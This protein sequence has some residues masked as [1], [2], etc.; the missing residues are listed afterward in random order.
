MS[1]QQHTVVPFLR[2]MVVTLGPVEEWQS[3]ASG[4]VLEF[5]SD[6][7][8]DSFRIS[9]NIQKTV[10]GVPNP[11]T[12]NI[13]NLSDKTRN[14]LQRSLTKITVEA[15]WENT[16]MHKVFQG[17]LVS[18]QS[19]RQGA[20]IVTKI[21]AI[22]GYGALVRSTVSKTYGEG[23]PIQDVL[24]DLGGTLEGVTVNS[25]HFKEVQGTLGKGGWSFAG[26]TQD[27]MTELASE[28]GFSW[29]IDDN[30]LNAIGDKAKFDGMVVLYGKDGGLINVSPI[31]QGPMQVQTG[32]KISAIY[33]PGVQPGSTVR[34]RSTVSQGLDGDYRIHTAAISLD[35]FSDAW[36]MQLE[37]FRYM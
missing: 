12:I 17:S 5:V 24:K 28:Y 15:G 30:S 1:Q 32:V 26:R 34:V 20:D 11:S 27:A 35:T 33:V 2:K 21:A 29:N 37:S 6:G 31:L 14:A 25:D 3:G 23:M 7:T 10:M 8:Q 18:C 4:D 19:A 16:E 22:P 13:Y 9:A 36:T